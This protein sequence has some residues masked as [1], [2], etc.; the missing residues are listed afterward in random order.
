MKQDLYPADPILL[1]DDEVDARK[2]AHLVL[3]SG[4]ISNTLECSDPRDV[5]DILA[6]QPVSAVLLDLVMPHLSGQELLGQIQ[7]EHPDIP[8]IIMTGTDDLE[9]AVA[10]MRRGASDY[11][12]KPVEE[13]QL[14][15][16]V[17]RVIDL[18]ELRYENLRLR[19]SMLSGRL[20]TPEAFSRIVTCD[21]GMMR[22]FQYIEAIAPS[23]KPVL[24]S[25]ETGV[26]KELIGRAIHNLSRRPGAFVGVNVGGL[27]DGLF[28]DTIF[29]HFRG[30][31]TNAHEK[32]SGAVEQAARG[33]LLLDEIGD[34]HPESQ[35]KLLRL[36]QEGEYYPLGSSA[37]KLADARIIAT[38]NQNI[39]NL[40]Q[41]AR[42]R[43]DLYY[44]LQTH[45]ILLPPLRE[46]LGDIPLLLHHFLQLS[47]QALE[48]PVP[49]VPPQLAPLLQSYPFPGNVRE[50]EGMVFDA[51]SRH[52]SRMLSMKSFEEHIGAPA[53]GQ[54]SRPAPTSQLS[55]SLRHLPRIPT[56]K[57]AEDEIIHQALERAEGNQSLA[58]KMLGISRQAL[59]RRLLHRA[60]S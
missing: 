22:I 52:R 36:L 4:R 24:I 19:Q 37:P 56:L 59:N 13:N 50:L 32:R 47:A 28:S 45:R 54:S 43:R 10:C 29:G 6:R 11:L 55:D 26:G 53:K 58:A 48:K 38:T 5:M 16:S 39:E 27:D 20:E 21:P 1:V 51:V 40:V 49:T 2:I 9:T 8:V 14:V 44:R 3:A 34:L 15:S 60:R 31:F 42:M 12:V 18:I 7:H 57:E 17:R 46:R 23:P 30:A 25:G 33:T 41:G 35:V